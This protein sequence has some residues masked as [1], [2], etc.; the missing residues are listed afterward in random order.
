MTTGED[1]EEEEDDDDDDVVVVVGVADE[2]GRTGTTGETVDWVVDVE[3]EPVTVE[4]VEV[5]AVEVDVEVRGAAEMMMLDVVEEEV[6]VEDVEELL[7]DWVTVG[8]T[9]AMTVVPT[10]PVQV[11]TLVL[12]DYLWLERM[13]HSQPTPSQTLPG[14]QHPPP[15]LSGQAVSPCGHPD[16]CWPQ[17]C[18]GSQQPTSPSPESAVSLQTRPVAQQLFGRFID[19]Q[20]DVPLGHEK[21]RGSCAKMDPGDR[22]KRLKRGRVS[23]WR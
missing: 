8:S 10:T 7:G 3:G 16:T 15:K 6:D 1:E 18:P 14:M 23:S 19:V 4:V 13:S 20:A 21:S 17:T 5:V 9:V 22:S 12:C 11:E 2:V